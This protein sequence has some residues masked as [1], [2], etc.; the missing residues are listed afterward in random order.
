ME[1]SGPENRMSG[2][3]KNTMERERSG[4]PISGGS[5]SGEQASESAA[6]NS[7]SLTVD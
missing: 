5:R 7:L 6:H 3:S 4:R 2:S 1:R